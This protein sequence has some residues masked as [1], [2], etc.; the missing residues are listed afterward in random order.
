MLKALDTFYGILVVAVFTGLGS[1]QPESFTASGSSEDRSSAVSKRGWNMLRLGRGLQML[2]LGKRGEVPI[3]RAARRSSEDSG[4]LDANELY[5]VLASIMDEPR[6]Q[7]RRQPPLPRYGRDSNGAA[8]DLLDSIGSEDSST[9]DLLSSLNN[10]PSYFRPA[11][12][13]GRYKRSL[14]EVGDND[15]SELEAYFVPGRPYRAV[16][17]PRIGRYLAS[18]RLQTKAVPRPRIGRN[19]ESQEE[20]SGSK[21]SA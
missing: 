13:G 17:L 10:G 6:D 19:L 14:P 18:P 4:R 8:R 12:R 2:R 15:F 20:T 9:Y 7:S 5:A 11:P 16:A 1:G 21:M 3:V